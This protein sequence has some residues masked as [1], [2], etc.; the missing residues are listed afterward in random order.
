MT[1]TIAAFGALNNESYDVFAERLGHYAEVQDVGLSLISA[2]PYPNPRGESE[3]GRPLRAEA[4]QDEQKKQQLFEAVAADARLIGAPGNDILAMP[5][6]SMIGFHDG[7]EK[8]LGKPIMRLADALAEKYR[9]VDKVGVIHMRPAKKRIEEI[10]GGKAVTPDERQAAA[11]L[12]AEEEAKNRKTPFPVYSAMKE[13]VEAWRTRGLQHVLF[14]RADAPRA[15]M[16][17]AGMVDG[18][19]INTYFDILAESVAKRAREI[20]GD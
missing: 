9:D 20:E 14:A 2:G 15:H 16:S 10:F 5:C 18:L 4:L 6:M 13:I 12:E 17:S 8:A 3:P 7:I 1:V 11:L 19:V